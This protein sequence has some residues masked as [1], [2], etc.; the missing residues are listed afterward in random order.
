MMYV[1]GSTCWFLGFTRTVSLV[2]D[3]RNFSGTCVSSLVEVKVS[4]A[5]FDILSN[6]SFFH[7]GVLRV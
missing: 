4:F 7:I 1:G 5:I 3:L 2:D 6:L